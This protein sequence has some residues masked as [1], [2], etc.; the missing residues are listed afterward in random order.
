LASVALLL[1]EL[2][3]DRLVFL[4][5]VERL[6]DRLVFLLLV[7]RLALVVF[8]LLLDADLVSPLRLGAFLAVDFVLRARARLAAVLVPA[9]TVSKAGGPCLSRS[10]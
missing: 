8:L 6:E 10:T 9:S 2:L 3:E 4:L 7:E 1:V 5:L